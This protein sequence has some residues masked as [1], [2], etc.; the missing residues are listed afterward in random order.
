VL[1][2]LFAAAH[3]AGLACVGQIYRP[4]YA[5]FLPRAQRWLFWCMGGAL[6]SV[7]L[8]AW[9]AGGQSSPGLL[10]LAALVG[11]A[12]PLFQRWLSPVRQASEARGARR[13]A[14]AMAAALVLA[15][16][17]HGLLSP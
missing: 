16:G 7:T 3:G 9:V 2:A 11:W 14:M 6:V 12:A 5:G 13:M 17:L 15:G 4:R 1:P 10:G 8:A